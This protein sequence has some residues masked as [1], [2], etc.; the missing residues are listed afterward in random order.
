MKKLFF[1]ICFALCTFS[2]AQNTGLAIQDNLNSKDNTIFTDIKNDIHF[3]DI[4]NGLNEII[5]IFDENTITIKQLQEKLEQIIVTTEEQAKTIK[6]LQEALRQAQE[7]VTNA[8]NQVDIAQDR[9]QDA[10]YFAKQVLDENALLKIENERLKAQL[11]RGYIAGISFGG[12]LLSSGSV[13]TY[14]I[15]N[16]N[17]ISNPTSYNLRQI[18]TERP[19]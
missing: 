12:V 9:M 10:E 18:L 17:H 1:I 4:K 7:A 14:G 3:E 13:M 11:T 6:E 5:G 19:G 16:N 15:I 8:R 2:F